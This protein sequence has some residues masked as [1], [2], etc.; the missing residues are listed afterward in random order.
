MKTVLVTEAQFNEIVAL[1]CLKNS[2]DNVS[3]LNE[4]R[5][6][7][8]VLQYIRNALV[9]GVAVASIITA[10]MSSDSLTPQEKTEAVTY[11]KKYETRDSGR[12]VLDD[13][14]DKHAKD[15]HDLKVKELERCMQEKYLR[16]KG[17]KDYNPKD[18]EL[19]AEEMV[20]ACE[21]TGYDL[22]LAA[23]Q[24]WQESAWGTTP[25]AKDTKSVFSVG[26]YD[27]GVNAV[28]YDNVDDSIRPYINLMQDKYEMNPATLDDIFS[29]KRELM[30]TD[31]YRYAQYQDYE[32][33]L[34]HIYN[35]IK[36]NYP[37]LSWDLETYYK[38]RVKNNGIK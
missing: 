38:E 1:E 22:V 24:A 35:S 19:S 20:Q 16:L 7:K 8:T 6:S 9:A 21:D 29:G 27:N 10:I 18:I 33:D 13:F 26:S 37:I 36:K 12:T 5:M 14:R 11:V 3:M 15:L 30:S 34:K 4:G 31:G 17:H 25:R 2:L 32:K 23:A 28:R